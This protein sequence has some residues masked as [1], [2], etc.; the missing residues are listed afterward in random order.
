VDYS[1]LIGV[2]DSSKTL[3]TGLIDMLSVFNISKLLESK[4]KQVLKSAQRQDKEQV[5]I[6]KPDDCTGSF[7]LRPPP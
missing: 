5:T 4:S 2:D 1:L 6:V 3:V 7:R